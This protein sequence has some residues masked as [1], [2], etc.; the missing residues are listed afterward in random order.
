MTHKEKYV[1][2]TIDLNHLDNNLVKII[3]DYLNIIKNNNENVKLISKEEITKMSEK[4]KNLFNVNT[5]FISMNKLKPN[6][7]EKVLLNTKQGEC[8]AWRA[9]SENEDIYTIFLTDNVLNNK[10]ILGWRYL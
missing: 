9:N 3:N 10:D 4:I 8:I 1:K 5:T 7:Y 6:Y 2:R